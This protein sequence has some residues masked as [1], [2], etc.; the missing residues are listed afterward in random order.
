MAGWANGDVL[1]LDA[2]PHA[3]FRAPPNWAEC[4]IFC[5]VGLR[6][7]DLALLAVGVEVAM[8]APRFLEF[9]PQSGGM[10][11][12]IGISLVATLPPMLQDAKRL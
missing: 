7:V 8:L 10:A 12:R 9:V 3:T 5:V 2:H 6:R 1:C 11:A 4:A